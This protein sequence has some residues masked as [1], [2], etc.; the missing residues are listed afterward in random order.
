MRIVVQEDLSWTRPVD[1]NYICY[2]VD[3]ETYIVH[4][5]FVMCEVTCNALRLRRCNCS[6]SLPAVSLLCKAALNSGDCI[7]P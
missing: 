6:D 3:K 1:E 2:Q 4:V 7:L 5:S